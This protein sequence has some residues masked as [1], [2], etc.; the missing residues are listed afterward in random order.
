MQLR[1][2]FGVGW[3]REALSVVLSSRLGKSDEV[4]SCRTAIAPEPAKSVKLEPVG[5]SHRRLGL[6]SWASP[7]NATSR[8]LRIAA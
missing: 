5:Q 8:A 6:R 4:R 2:R 1:V 3:V 7:T